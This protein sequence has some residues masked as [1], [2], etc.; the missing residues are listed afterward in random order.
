MAF[1]LNAQTT[2]DAIDI[3]EKQN[4]IM[5]DPVML[6]GVP[7]LNVSYERFLNKDSGVGFNLMLELD[8]SNLFQ[9]SP[10]YRMYFGQEYASGFFIEGFV[11]IYL[12]K[13]KAYLN[14][15]D[16]SQ[17][18]SETVNVNRTSIGIGFGLGKKWVIKKNIIFELSAGIGRLIGGEKYNYVSNLTGKGTLG[19]G[20]RF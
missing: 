17:I 6:V 14:E 3:S 16:T 15:D 5:G 19:I 1:N 9:I 18:F 2:G 7:L 13:Q 4:D 8:N 11:P 12:G 20:Y 10:Y